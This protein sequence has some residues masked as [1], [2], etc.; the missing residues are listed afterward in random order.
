MLIVARGGTNAVP[1]WCDPKGDNGLA[2]EVQWI[3]RLKVLR[4]LSRLAWRLGRQRN[5]T[6]RLA[7]PVGLEPAPW[8]I[9]PPAS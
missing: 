5:A 1:D 7:A 8:P 2:G 6:T 3:A 9:Q 4:E